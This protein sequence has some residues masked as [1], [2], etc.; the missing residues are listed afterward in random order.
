MLKKHLGPEPTDDTD[1]PSRAAQAY[2]AAY[3]TAA[4]EYLQF[5]DE[6]RAY[7]CLRQGA[8]LYPALL[9]QLSTFFELS[10]GNQPK[11]E[12]GHFTTLDLAHNRQV[13]M[14]LLN[15]LFLAI[16]DTTVA[17]AQLRQS[18][19]QIYALADFTFGLL[20]YGA[21][22]FTPARRYLWRALRNDPKL[23]SNQ[24]LLATL[25]RT[26]FNPRVVEWVR[27]QRRRNR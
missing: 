8:Q 25:T 3:L 6:A 2:G 27:K 20:N 26:Y 19:R 15:R 4:V 1:T 24:Q 12:R 9:L 23:R 10:C 11:G 17:A 13:L 14:R 22:Q 16:D 21:S 18:K 5:G 7:D